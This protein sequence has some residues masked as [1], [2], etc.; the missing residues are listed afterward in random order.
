MDDGIIRPAK[1]DCN[2]F[3]DL[4]TADDDGVAFNFGF[5]PNKFPVLTCNRKT[6]RSNQLFALLRVPKPDG[7]VASGLA[8]VQAESSPTRLDFRWVCY[9]AVVQAFSNVV[10]TDDG[11]V[12]AE[13]HTF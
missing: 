8:R 1:A 3:G 7:D 6:G 2:R 12:P 9:V 13:L 4:R 5:C 10:K 11:F